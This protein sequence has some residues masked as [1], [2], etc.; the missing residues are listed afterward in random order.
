MNYFTAACELLPEPLGRELETFGDAEEIRLRAGKK[1]GFIECGKENTFSESIVNQ[2]HILQVIEKATGASLHSALTSLSHGYIDYKGLRIGVCGQAVVS[3]GRFTGFGN[4]S[5][6]DIRIPHQCLEICRDS[7]EDIISSGMESTLIIGP[8]GAGKTT[9]LREA[10]RCISNSGIRVAVADERNEI[11]GSV[12][13][14]PQFDLGPYTDVISNLNKSSAAMMLLRGMNP[15]VIAMD[16]ITE[17][18]DLSVLSEI[19][20]CGISV[21]ATAHGKERDEMEK[22]SIYKSLLGSGIFKNLLR[23]TYK[24]GKREYELERI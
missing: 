19:G 8:P 23:I 3:D 24:N 6:L 13:G 10:I 14:I 16:E 20:G 21:L 22:R 12:Q 2:N 1:P 7:I 5:S 4:Y 18:D 11:S 9:V 15:Q 17:P